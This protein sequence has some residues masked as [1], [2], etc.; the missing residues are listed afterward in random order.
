MFSRLPGAAYILK[1]LKRKVPSRAVTLETPRI[2][3]EGF[4]EPRTAT[5][6]LSMV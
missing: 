5:L 4:A 6:A 2:E 3:A 1:S